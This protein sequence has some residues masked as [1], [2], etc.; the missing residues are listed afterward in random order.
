M[1][2]KQYTVGK[3]EPWTSLDIKGN[4][5]ETYRITFTTALGDVGFV[6]LARDGFT[7][8]AASKA[9]AAEAAKLIAVRS[10]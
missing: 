5:Y 1:P 3:I 10:L 6:D 9:V 2:E 8:E 7:K 4:P